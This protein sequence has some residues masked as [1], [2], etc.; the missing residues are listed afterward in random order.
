MDRRR[1]ASPLL[2]IAVP[3]LTEAGILA[4]ALTSGPTKWQGIAQ[5]PEKDRSLPAKNGKYCRLDLTYALRPDR[6]GI[7]R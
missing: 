6:V 7:T 1:T 3:S 4:E 2:S 5:V